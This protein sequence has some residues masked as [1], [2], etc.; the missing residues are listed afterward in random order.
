MRLSSLFADHPQWACP[1][2]PN[3]NGAARYSGTCNQLSSSSFLW[4]Q[5]VMIS[6]PFQ[7]NMLDPNDT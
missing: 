3:I 2:W 4:T 7:K 5:S 1:G 6:N